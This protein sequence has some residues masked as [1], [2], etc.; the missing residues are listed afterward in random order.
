MKY[1]VAISRVLDQEKNV[2][3]RPQHLDFLKGQEAQGRIFARGPFA[4]GSGGLV[5]YRAESLQEATTL[6]E[7]DP[8]VSHGAR[9][10]ELH[11][12]LM[13]AQTLTT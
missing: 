13:A 9:R 12:W 6:A 2:T 4:N 5:I 3:L 10:L 7:S 8:Y 11:E 1:F